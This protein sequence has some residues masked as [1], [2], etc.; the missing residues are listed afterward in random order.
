[1]DQIKVTK[2]F[3]VGNTFCQATM[4]AGDEHGSGSGAGLEPDLDIFWPDWIGA[5]LGFCAGPDR[6]QIVMS[7]VCQLKYATM[8]YVRNS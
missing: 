5:G 7:W 4:H 1:M 8:S 6:S 3:S 2:H